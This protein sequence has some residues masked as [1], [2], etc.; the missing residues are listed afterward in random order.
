MKR[1]VFLISLLAF[2]FVGTQ[3]MN[4][5]VI[6]KGTSLPPEKTGYVILAVYGHNGHAG[7]TSI[8]DGSQVYPLYLYSGYVGAISYFYVT[9]GRYTVTSV[10]CTDYATFNNNKIETG[11]VIDFKPGYGIAEIIYQ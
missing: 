5:E 6:S 9:P 1:I 2:L 8:S 11:H 3:N 4:S 10:S 7:F